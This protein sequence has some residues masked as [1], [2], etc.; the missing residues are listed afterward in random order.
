MSLCANLPL[1]TRNRRT[2]QTQCGQL[3][4]DLVNRRNKGDPITAGP[5]SAAI[6]AAR[7][8]AVAGAN[9][10]VFSNRACKPYTFS[11]SS[12]ALRRS[13]SKRAPM[14]VIRLRD[15]AARAGGV[16]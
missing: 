12:H 6:A 2:L 11:H 13:P 16:T 3:Q 15:V 1:S 14:T 9:K 7:S 8:A 5:S 4:D 10:L